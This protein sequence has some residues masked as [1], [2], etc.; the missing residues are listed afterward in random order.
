MPHV[1]SIAYTPAYIDRRPADRYARAAVERAMLIANHG[2][3]G[4]VKAKPGNRQLNVMLAETVAELRA[5]GLDTSPGE[6]GEQ[7]VIAGL[8]ERQ[9]RPGVHIRLGD[10]ALIELDALRTPC[11]RFAR[12]QGV[13]I[14]DAIGRIGYMAR[15]LAGG[16][17]SVGSQAVIET[18]VAGR[19]I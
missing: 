14:T 13:D 9:V 8:D 15:V 2:I 12:I 18:D 16:E 11:D 17:I 19:T 7:L 4:D 5:D 3:E 1:V 6:L 10:A